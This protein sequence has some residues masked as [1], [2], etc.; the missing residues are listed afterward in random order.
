MPCGIAIIHYK[1]CKHNTL[2]KLDCTVGCDGL[3]PPENQETLLITKYMWRCEDCHYRQTRIEDLARQT[4]WE[5]AANKVEDEIVDE[6]QVAGP[7]AEVRAA[8][9]DGVRAREEYENES[10]ALKRAA[11]MDE[12]DWVEQWTSQYGQL[13]WDLKYDPGVDVGLTDRRKGYLLSVKVWDL[14]VVKDATRSREVLNEEI[15]RY[16]AIMGGYPQELQPLLEK[17][18]DLDPAGKQANA[19]KADSNAATDSTGSNQTAA[20]RAAGNAVVTDA[21]VTSTAA[22]D[23]TPADATVTDAMAIDTASRE[24]M[25]TDTTTSQR[26]ATDPTAND[27]PPADAKTGSEVIPADA[28]NAATVAAAA[29]AADAA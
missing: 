11:Q 16:R 19:G 6:S 15:Q 8:R 28:A 24:T 25:T 13:L 14:L 29:A 5:T 23:T 21:T 1:Q 10:L 4:K 7:M 12:I 20:G 27:G 26:I 18:K 3:C 22:V 9:V 17:W 2:F